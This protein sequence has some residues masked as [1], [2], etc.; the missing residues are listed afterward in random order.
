MP[1]DLDEIRALLAR[2]D[3]PGG[4]AYMGEDGAFPMEIRTCDGFR[5]VVTL[6]ADPNDTARDIADLPTALADAVAEI[7]RLTSEVDRLQ[8]GGCA[9]D[10]RTTQFC[11]EAVAKDAEIRRL[12]SEL[13]AAQAGPVVE[14]RRREYH[15]DAVIG[16]F[17]LFVHRVGWEIRMQDVYGERHPIV[18][19]PETG[20]AGKT[21]CEASYRR[22]I[23]L[24]RP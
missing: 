23:G 1:L 21:A 4:W 24:S 12:T 19:G 13:A 5:E 16:R 18:T 15:E 2:I 7:D 6:A 20:D 11:A 9:R 8:A 3:A 14:W 22:A 10:Q 17:S